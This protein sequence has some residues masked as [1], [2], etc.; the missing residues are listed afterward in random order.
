MD[1]SAAHVRR[2]ELRWTFDGDSEVL[3]TC[4]SIV[5]RSSSLEELEVGCNTPGEH[6]L[7][8]ESSHAVHVAPLHQSALSSLSGWYG[9]FA[10]LSQQRE[11]NVLQYIHFYFHLI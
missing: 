1:I 5:S 7:V 10:L 4:L 11:R 6:S 2:L 8:A 9:S 3:R